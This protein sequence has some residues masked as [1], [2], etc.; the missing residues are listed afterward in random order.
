MSSKNF[1]AKKTKDASTFL[2]IIIALVWRGTIEMQQVAAES[3]NLYL[4]ISLLHCVNIY[5]TS[6]IVINL[7][8]TENMCD[9]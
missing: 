7:F 1:P 4:R 3:A 6:I 9:A 5:G 8:L 2:G